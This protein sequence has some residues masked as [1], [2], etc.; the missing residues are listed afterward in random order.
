[1]APDADVHSYLAGTGSLPTL[2]TLS[3]ASLLAATNPDD[4]SQPLSSTLANLPSN[5][6]QSAAAAVVSG[7]NQ[8]MA[9]GLSTSPPTPGQVNS[10]SLDFSTGVPTYAFTTA[11]VTGREAALPAGGHLLVGDSA[12]WDDV[13]NDLHS[14]E[15]SIRKGLHKVVTVV[16]QWSEEAAGWIINLAIDVSTQVAQFVVNSLHSA[17]TAIHGIFNAIAV[18]AETVVRWIRMGLDDVIGHAEANAQVVMSWIS[19]TFPAFATQQLDGIGT[20]ADGFFVG[21]ETDV[22]NTI[23]EIKGDLGDSSYNDLLATQ[24]ASTASVSGLLGSS[25]LTDITNMLTGVH[26][27]W[28]IDK[29]KSA[30]DHGP[31]NFATNPVLQS[32]MEAASNGYQSWG[33]DAALAT[34]ASSLWSQLDSGNTI[35]KGS[36]FAD[37][38]AVA[39]LDALEA[40]IVD[41][42]N[43]ADDVVNESLTLMKDTVDGLAEM[44]TTTSPGA[45]LIVDVLSKLGVHADL[46]YGHVAGMVAMFPTT[47]VYQF[48]TQDGSTLFP[49][50]AYT[51]TTSSVVVAQV[52]ETTTDYALSLKYIHA[53]SRALLAVFQSFTDVN[54]AQ[55]GF[56]QGML[57][58]PKSLLIFTPFFGFVIAA[59]T[60]PG[61]KNTDGT[62]ARPF[63]TAPDT[64]NVGADLVVAEMACGW[65]LFLMGFAFTIFPPGGDSAIRGEL[66]LALNEIFAIGDLGV[67]SAA[68]HLTSADEFTKATHCLERTPPVLTFCVFKP[69]LEGTDA[70]SFFVK[71]FSDSGMDLAAGG[72]LLDAATKAG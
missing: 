36:D 66:V 32:D 30:I 39:L 27:N 47:L 57:T 53:I 24:P 69:V 68:D 38:A 70:L 52:G 50:S 72:M 37:L 16:A 62:T 67:T 6:Q 25:A 20:L 51:A 15:R 7:L 26:H 3:S 2:G 46:S 17:I 11:T 12:W 45:Q 9:A 61:V 28:L 34:L 35:G 42:L 19:Q 22:K 29:I 64:A 31:P 55:S 65:A 71:T 5:S 4:P 8:S 48:A 58:L 23:G 21:L 63:T 60:Y 1:V 56:T 41:L 43:L 14:L 40:G 13:K 10:F 54:A 59:C 33:G 44:L 18:D 49:S